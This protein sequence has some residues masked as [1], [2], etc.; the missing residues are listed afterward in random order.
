MRSIL[1]FRLVVVWVAVA[2]AACQLPAAIV[3]EDATEPM[4]R[5]DMPGHTSEVRALA[6]F[7]GSTRL[8]SGGRDKV[9][10]IWNSAAGRPPEAAAERTRD[11]GRRRL[12]ERVLRWQVARGTRGAI[13]ALAV[14]RGDRP[15]VALAGSGAMG[16]T[17]EIVLIDAKDG[18]LAAVLG[19]GDKPGHRNSVLAVAF[20]TDGNWLFS[21]DFDGQCFAWKRDE[22]WRP[23][24][25]AARE[26]DRYGSERT[27]GIQKLPRLRPLAA[28]D[29]GRVALPVLV[30]PVGASP[31]VWRIELVDPGP[32]QQRTVLPTDHPG[33]V[34]AMAASANGRF[35]VSADLAGQVHVHDLQD[36]NDTGKTTK[37][38]SFRVESAAE[39]IALS[40]DGRTVVLGLATAGSGTS[41]A[42]FEVWDVT[43]SQR[44]FVR[45]MPSSVRAVALSDDGSL[46]AWTGGWQHEVFVMPVRDLV[47][48]KP[49]RGQLGGVG[50]RIGRVAFEHQAN[51]KDGQAAPRRIAVAWDHPPGSAHEP[52]APGTAFDAAFDMTRLAVIDP[53][54]A[55]RLAPPE[56]QRGSWG[57][58][59]ST[60]QPAGV[61]AWQVS[62]DGKPAGVILLELDW[63]GRMGPIDRCVAWL[64]P[65]AGK[66]QPPAATDPWAVAVGTDRGIFV[67]RLDSVPAHADRPLSIVRRYRGHEDGVA[68][69]AVSEDG[70]WLASGGHDGI[71]MLWPLP[72]MDAA[73]LFARFGV[74]L[75]VE[76][77]KAKVVSIDEA[78]PLAGRGVSVGDVLA[79]VS[80]RDGDNAARTEAA[81]GNAVITAL[82]SAPWKSQWAFVVERAGHAEEPFNRQPAWENIAAF[83]L[84]DNREWAF[85]SPRGYYAASA[86]GDSR[87]G[88]LVNRG[89]E[90]LPRFHAARQLRRTLERPDVMTHL[91]A[92][93]SLAGALRRAA[94]HELDASDASA[95]LLPRLIA[96]APEVRILSPEAF[97]A[98]DGASLVV[99][100]T[101]EVPSGAE[102]TDVRAYASGVV[103]RGAGK[104]VAE[105][106]E[107]DGP[108]VRTYEWQVDLPEEAEQLIQV[109]A[110]TRDGPTDVG[111]TTIARRQATAQRRPPRLHLVAAGIN[112]YLHSD[113][114]A[115]EGL[116]DLL[117]ATN[118]AAAVRD[119]LLAHANPYQDQGLS[120]DVLLR[121]GEVTHDQWQKQL[122]GM[123]DTIAA[124]V[125][126]DDLVVIFLAGHGMIV[127]ERERGYAYLCHDVTFEARG[128][129]MVPAESATIGWD[130]LRPLA[131]LPCRKLALIDS[132]HAGALAPAN[133]AATAR[134]FQENMVLVLS[135]SADDESSLESDAWGH[136]AFTKVLLD[137]LAGKADTR[138]AD[139]RAGG[140]GIVRLDEVIDYVITHVPI[141]AASQN[142]GQHPTIAPD[143]LVPY[144]TPPLTKR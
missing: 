31:P 99:R 33:V 127:P 59:R 9:A 38:T 142:A 73:A 90:R 93:G 105:H 48:N 61:E 50:R 23:V 120:T 18:S 94:Q 28:V 66:E 113:R 57:I 35:L 22:A 10:I 24:E 4:L 121:D 116:T 115:D 44:T 101:V 102:L 30:S 131:A 92:E 80:A 129:E 47:A 118:D 46:A 32:K 81:D 72:G 111:E 117:Y 107:K 2:M 7:P 144:V 95:R 112:N 136:G 49:V 103:A 41:V 65:P 126:P 53:P 19:G 39:S 82:A 56:G 5:L 36:L 60:A 96:S 139:G 100:A 76:A 114:F 124:D 140:D 3:R 58:A 119:S 89:L 16:S 83:Y 52:R 79:K 137:A 11:I 34:T 40:P 85:W 54:P 25:L 67:Y 63:Q 98:A 15:L 87:F 104:V 70:R 138:G 110:G 21:Q 1:N 133:R 123:V 88:W 135:A 42:R 20:S 37:P 132:C 143:A 45:E 125:T 26:R 62:R 75:E 8:V 109:F 71:V 130:D 91:L 78:G 69:I 51:E 6:F 43:T 12:L 14:S 55:D 29:G 74:G 106:V 108:T 68:A 86:N 64:T 122:A 134:D 13:Q 128:N 141:L 97:E 27:T 77:G 17:G 84:A